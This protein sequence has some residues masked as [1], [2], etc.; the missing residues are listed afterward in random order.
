LY[1]AFTYQQY[2]Y[3]GKGNQV[4]LGSCVENKIK[5]LFPSEDNDYVGFQLSFQQQLDGDC[6]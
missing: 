4:Q 6:Y 1:R 5:E 2:G 3:L